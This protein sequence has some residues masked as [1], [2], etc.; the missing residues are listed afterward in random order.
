MR[1]S[2]TDAPI[3]RNPFPDP[4]HFPIRQAGPAFEKRNE[5]LIPI[6]PSARL[7]RDVIG[8]ILLMN[9]ERISERHFGSI[10]VYHCLLGSMVAEEFRELGF[11]N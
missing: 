5:N 6:V 7:D 3:Q 2:E 1:F 8:E 9:F 11:R 10:V 4:T